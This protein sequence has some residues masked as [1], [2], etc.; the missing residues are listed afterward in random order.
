MLAVLICLDLLS[1]R[2][3]SLGQG[4]EQLLKFCPKLRASFLNFSRIPINTLKCFD[5]EDN[6]TNNIPWLL[7]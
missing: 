3:N 7:V 1:L 6:A 5:M 4:L 2:V